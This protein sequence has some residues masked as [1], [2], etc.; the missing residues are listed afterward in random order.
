MPSTSNDQTFLINTA[1]HSTTDVG[2]TDTRQPTEREWSDSR[3]TVVLHR[4]AP[5]TSV[6]DDDGVLITVY[7]F[8]TE[9]NTE[10]LTSRQIS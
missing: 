7:V 10:P 6:D 5:Q 2:C 8:T 4:S 3:C 1:R 9:Y